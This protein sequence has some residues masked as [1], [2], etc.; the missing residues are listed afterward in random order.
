M[1]K[2]QTQA[3]LEA[4]MA[5]AGK[6]RALTS[7]DKALSRSEACETPAGIALT[8]RAIEPV[9]TALK[10]WLADALAGTAGRKASAALLL[11][12]VDPDLASYLAVKAAINAAVKEY[13]LLYAAGECGRMIDGEIRAARFEAAEPAL[14]RAIVNSARDRGTSPARIVNSLKMAEQKFGLDTQGWTRDQQ[15]H[16]G[17]KLVELVA[18]TLGII[19]VDMVRTSARRQTHRLYLTADIRGWMEQFNGAASATRP[20]YLP[21]VDK[22]LPWAA[23]RGGG[24]HTNAVT[25]LTL[26]TRAR[27]AQMDALDRADLSQVYSAI[28][29]IQDT[30]WRIN[31]RVLAVMKDVWARNSGLGGVPPQHDEPVPQMPP[32]I[33]ALASDH[34]DR[35]AFR[36]T[37]RDVH[38]RNVKALADRFM[39][40]R[41]VRLADDF[42]AYDRFYFPHRCDFRGRVYPTCDVL[43]PQGDDVTKALLEFADGK[44][45]GDQMGPTWF[46]IHGANLF[47]FDKV[48]F[49]DREAWCY[50]HSSAMIA[51]ALDPLQNRWWTEADKPWGFL[52]FCFEWQG[53]IRDGYAHVSHMPIAMDGS[54]NGLQHFAAMLRD[55]TTGRAVNLVPQDK[56]QDIYQAVADATVALLS[57]Y[58]S[59]KD[60]DVA[61][62]W[63]VD[64]WLTWGIDRKI[65]KRPVMVLPYGGTFKSCMDYV[66]GA[67]QERVKAGG[68]VSP[69]GLELRKASTFLARFVWQAMDDIIVA[70]R[71]AMNYIQAVARQTAALNEPFTWTAPSGFP[72]VQAYYET[73]SREIA[74]RFHGK[75]VKLKENIATAKIDARQQAAGAAPNF[76]HSLDASAMMLTINAA[77]TRGVSHFAMIH[78]SYGTHAADS[79]MLAVV[80]RSEFVRMYEQN[81]VLT[82]LQQHTIAEHLLLVQDPP[83]KGDLDLQTVNSSQYFFA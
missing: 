51:C 43:N 28:N 34:P 18:E 24:Y 3:R 8:K 29:A 74:T 68:G 42:A 75:I 71:Q 78:D 19:T 21:T 40:D 6:Q 1:S 2:Q 56:P 14:Y 38:M 79:Q 81:D 64:A 48:A 5:E 60:R 36:R 17:T 58:R 49:A 82:Q 12:G 20:M 80:L 39:F 27:D 73:K 69:F 41:R 61:H 37:M 55:T 35:R 52:A 66:Y 22:P 32:A 54:C 45:L 76:V 30:P 72:V 26:I 13:T 9:S 23:P 31:Q 77:V 44:P 16:V 7:I 10:A 33:E 50:A 59:H 53:Y 15:V 57:T 83:P 46:A 25:P 67:A 11:E 47:G 62:D 65:T 4:R 70:G 63:I